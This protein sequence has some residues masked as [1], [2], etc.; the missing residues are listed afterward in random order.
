MRTGE[1]LVLWVKVAPDTSWRFVSTLIALYRFPDDSVVIVGKLYTGKPLDSLKDVLMT[2]EQTTH[3]FSPGIPIARGGLILLDSAKTRLTTSLDSKPIL[4]DFSTLQG[5]LVFTSTLP[6][7]TAYTHEFY[8][9]NMQGIQQT[10]SLLSLNVP[11]PGWKYGLWAVDTNFTPHQFFFYGHFI[12]SQGHDSDSANDHYPYPGGWKP[13]QMD[14]ATGNIIV[15]LEPEF[16]GDS[17]RFKGP[18]AFTLLKFKRIRSI[19]KDKNY[20]MTNSSAKCMPS[21]WITFRKN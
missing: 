5:S 9:M 8:L 11:P 6:N 15:T 7:T 10:P 19:E 16:Y 17:L 14:M 3:P 18:S 2:V 13:Q 1:S 4:G 12:S 21:G 20:L